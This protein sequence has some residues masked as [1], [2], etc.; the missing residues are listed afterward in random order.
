MTL[1]DAVLEQAGKV[2]DLHLDERSSVVAH[3]LRPTE[4]MFRCVELCAGIACS[5][6]GL[7]LAGFRHVCSGEWRSPFVD[8]HRVTKPGVT[9]VQGDICDP[10]CLKEVASKVDPPFTL[11]TG[12]SCQPY[13]SG[14]SQG[15]SSD[16]RSSTVPATVRAVHLLQSPLLIVENVTQ[17]RTNQFVRACLQQLATV[18]GYH[19]SELTMKLE[20]NWC[21]RRHRWWLIASHP[22]LGPVTLS[23]WPKNPSLTIRDVMPFI[24]SWSIEDL[25]QLRL[26]PLEESKFTLD[27]SSLRRYMIQT[28]G[29]L[30]TSL[31]S[32]GSQA[33]ECPCGCRRAFSES[34]LRQR[35]VYA[36]LIQLHSAAGT[37]GYRHL[38]PIELALLNAMLPP[39]AWMSH[40]RPSLRLCLSA[41]GQLA[42][43]MQSVWI[44]SCVMQQLCTVLEL[45]PVSPFEK[46][47]TLK[48]QLFG[49]A[50]DLFPSLAKDPTPVAWTTLTYPDG[51][52]VRV[53]VQPETTV[54]ELFQA[55]LALS[56]DATSDQWIDASTGNQLDYSTCVAGLTILVKGDRHSASASSSGL[57]PWTSDV[58]PIPVLFEDPEQEDTLED[59]EVP[60]VI[61]ETAAERWLAPVPSVGLGLEVASTASAD[62][63][64][65]MDALPGL[66]HLSGAQ[67]VALVPPL[68]S[69]VSSC[70]MFRRTVVSLE[71][72]LAVLAN[73]ELAMGDDELNLHLMACIKLS[74]RTDVQYLDPLLAGSWLQSGTVDCVREWMANT[75]WSFHDCHGRPCPKVIG[76]P[77]CGLLESRMSR[78]AMWEHADVDVD[79]LN[80]LHGLLS[81]SWGRP[82]F[83]LACTRRSFARGLCGAAS[84]AFVSHRLLGHDLPSSE[85]A[86]MS[87]HQD[88]KASFADTCRTAPV[89]L[90]PWCWG[91][92][93]ADVIGLTS[94]LLQ[95]HGVP[96][97]QAMLRAKL[98]V[99]SLGKLEVQKAVLGIAPWKSLKVLANMQ[100]PPLQMVL[101]DEQ[102][103]HG[104]AKQPLKGGG[105]PK[106]P[107][108]TKKVMPSRPADLD[109]SKLQLEPGAFC[110]GQDEPVCQIPFE[111]FGPLAVGVALATYQDALPFLQAGQ[112]LTNHGLALLVLNPP[113]DVSTALI[114]STV[115]FA[116]RCSMNQEPMIVSGL[117]V[118]LGRACVYQFTAKDTPAV[119]ATEAACARITVYQDQWENDWEDFANRPVKHVLSV[120]QCLQ[121]CRNGDQCT[122]PCW[123]PKP[124][125]PPD[126]VLDVFRRQFF[127]ETGRPVKW[128][129]AAY[130]AFF[131]R[132]VKS[133]EHGVLTSSGLHG[134]YVEPKTE[135]AL[136]PHED[137]QVVW[138]PQLDFGSIVHRAKCEVDCLGLA[139][140]GKRY[141]LRVHVQ[142]FQQLFRRVKPDAV[143][144]APGTRTLYHCGPWPF[145]SDRKS[146]AKTLKACNWECRPLQPV[147]HVSGG[148]MWSVQAVDEP[149]VRVLSMQHGQVVITCPDQ[150]T[151]A[152]AMPD[153]V[154]GHA[155][156]L[157]LCRQTDA[158]GQ[159]PW[160]TNDPWSKAVSNVSPMP[161]GPP[162]Q[163][164]LQELE[165]RIEQSIL[166]RLP[167]TDK[168]EVDDQD[169]RLQMLEAQVHQLTTR[170]ASLETTVQDNHQ[171]NTAQ[172]QSLQQQMKV[173]LDL[174]THQMQSM[175]TDQMARIETILAKKPRTE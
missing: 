25:E 140:T 70:A 156:T 54:I 62:P 75:P 168:M 101:P 111:N 161:A 165:Q 45:P 36:Q 53:Q 117:L 103:Q 17:A 162:A 28:E 6:L 96:A 160:L 108:Q 66:R 141:G 18:L 174:Q 77:L 129:K 159:D 29:K 114:W 100:T 40:D 136:R 121:T 169:Q 16:E 151:A 4:D 123:H 150:K 65:I 172:V 122:C 57:P 43:P 42:S 81:A 24:K 139:R 113:G 20:D 3:G 58:T 88:L 39:A 26:S 37:I 127:T 44:G 134:I 135:D 97:G 173:Q 68:V 128:D 154:V 137:Y 105:K 102:A 148:L 152:P 19:I 71:A 56:Q 130:F 61:S 85:A 22:A 49:F 74:G 170:Q 91:F 87:L 60:P 38:H 118:Q 13:S 89:L 94:E 126:A 146:V 34:L 10:A 112:L 23:D 46:L 7:D 147:Q 142:K 163:P 82:M 124:D 110:V 99:Q 138:L 153:Q 125:Q 167:A 59:T 133:L 47:C 158:A 76:C 93:Q 48:S 78:L 31:H 107:P 72:R 116:A 145:G 32:C 171:Q 95:T 109:P 33:S 143:Y 63:G 21:A 92:G 157:D 27:G 5:S 73:E 132:Y 69:D 64:H 9:V 90:K 131:V 83:G 14:G 35:R 52:Q 12:F 149:P 86:L 30:P 164:V 8:L 15:G 120:L 144:L 175:L 51:T 41:I 104:A 84:V 115:R 80:P 1:F 119:V 2:L 166:S 106:K 11:M 155:S 50:R 55:E 67:L 98:V 79:C